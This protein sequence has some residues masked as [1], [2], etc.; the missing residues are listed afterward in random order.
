MNRRVQKESSLRKYPAVKA[1]E[2]RSQG[3]QTAA[4]SVFRAIPMSGET[5]ARFP[6]PAPTSLILNIISTSVRFSPNK[7]AITI[8][9]MR[10][11]YAFSSFRRK[12]LWIELLSV[13]FELGQAE[14]SGPFPI[15]CLLKQ[16]TPSTRTKPANS[17]KQRIRPSD[18]R[19]SISTSQSVSGGHRRRNQYTNMARGVNAANNL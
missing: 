12:S 4:H 10:I 18:R 2:C 14:N 11:Y 8:I 17:S 13:F 6:S 15:S 16:A 9:K 19:P 1:I 3:D 5:R 7:N